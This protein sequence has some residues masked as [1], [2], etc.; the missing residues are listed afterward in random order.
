MIISR[1]GGYGGLFSLFR[2][3]AKCSW[4]YDLLWFNARVKSL[5]NWGW[6]LSIERQS[7]L[8]LLGAQ[9]GFVLKFAESLAMFSCSFDSKLSQGKVCGKICAGGQICSVVALFWC[10]FDSKSRQS[11]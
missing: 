9:P 10:S 11:V 5:K 8:T 7:T 2:S 3:F 4:C 1:F 6:Y